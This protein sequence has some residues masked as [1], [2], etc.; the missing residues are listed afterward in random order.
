MKIIIFFTL[1]IFFALSPILNNNLNFNR[2]NREDS[3]LDNKNPKISAVSAK[4][5]IDNNWTDAKAAGICTGNGTYSE[6][7]II[8]DFVIDGG[9]TGNGIWIENSDVYFKIE[10]CTL[11]NSGNGY[12]Y[13]GIRLSNV[14][15]SQLINNNCSS[16]GYGIS[17]FYSYNNTISGNT[18]NNNNQTG[19]NLGSSNNNTISK[20]TANYNNYTGIT[21]NGNN[22]TIS[23]NTANYN[24]TSGMDIYTVDS[25]ISG[26]TANYNTFHEI[27]FPEM[28]A[29]IRIHCHDS[30]VI[31]NTA[32][33]NEI[34][35][36][37]MWGGEYNNVS[38]NNANNNNN[39]G[40]K[41]RFCE[42]N[43]ISENYANNNYYGI[44]LEMSY[45]N[46][47]SVNTANNNT[48]FGIYLNG[49]EYNTISGNILIGNDECIAE[50]SSLRNTFSDNDACT[51]GQGG[52]GIPGYNLFLLLGILSLVAIVIG[53]KVKKT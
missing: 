44:V 11:Y 12:P 7:Y 32:Y 35:G 49:S 53:K 27:F 15:N 2:G 41:F 42:Y 4:I 43:N 23:E 21:I 9:G 19:I 46:M 14:I 16:N 20:N 30:L 48:D 34:N 37:F 38:G 33:N 47:V 50:A 13:S 1:G 10:N 17:V 25:V 39:T 3:N 36:I 18:A 40:M 52:G 6:P 51:Y 29:G 24:P 45:H 8:E 22:N 26:N 31:G 5:H 28:G